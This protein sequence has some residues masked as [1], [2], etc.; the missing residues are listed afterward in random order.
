MMTIKTKIKIM[1]I[2]IDS[3]SNKKYTR[4]N[5][6]ITKDELKESLNV[7]IKNKGYIHKESIEHLIDTDINRVLVYSEMIAEI[8]RNQKASPSQEE[9]EISL[10]FHYLYSILR[11]N[12]NLNDGLSLEIKEV[13]KAKEGVN[14]GVYQIKITH[15]TKTKNNNN[16]VTYVEDGVELTKDLYPGYWL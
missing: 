16:V 8:A 13:H 5:R 2:T 10:F 1:E 12:S 3:V 7:L 11:I 9:K 14:D 15:K 6:T 4:Y